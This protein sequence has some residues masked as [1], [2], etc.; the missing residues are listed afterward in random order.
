M[1]SKA[2]VRYLQVLSVVTVV[3]SL[4][5]LTFVALGAGMFRF[6][7]RHSGWTFPHFDLAY[8]GLLF[9]N[10]FFLILL[11]ISAGLLWRLNRKGLFLMIAA[12]VSEL[13][14]YA[15]AGHV[16]FPVVVG[17]CRSRDLMMGAAGLGSAFLSP[18]LPQIYSAYPIVA[19]ILLF[20]G[21]P[22]LRAPGESGLSKTA[23]HNSHPTNRKA[24]V[25]YRILA[26]LTGLEAG[27]GL[28]YAALFGVTFPLLN[29][30][31]GTDIAHFRQ[32]SE[33]P[34]LLL[35]FWCM[36]ALNVIFIGL[37]LRSAVLLWRSLWRGAL[38]LIG[39]ICSEVFYFL[40]LRESSAF[41]PSAGD[42]L[43]KTVGDTLS[44]LAGVGNMGLS[45][46]ILT[47]FPLIAGILILLL[48][49]NLGSSEKG[50]VMASLE[51]RAL[52]R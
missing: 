5:G 17:A 41:L 4:S 10:C 13:V 39:V 18:L 8:F 24:V 9:A 34:H 47:G 46:Q 48:Y 32:S 49:L 11:L 15:W 38:F 6:V 21:Y 25:L 35:I 43:P 40:L 28:C 44:E 37:L 29:T 19:G 45:I 50:H 27:I 51:R 14:F 31:L 23:P 7:Q 42:G 26:V 36:T 12:L 2:S 1:K 52:W 20:R 33:P 30:S 16:V 22:S 3:E